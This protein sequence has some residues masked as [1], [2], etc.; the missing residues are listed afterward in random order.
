MNFCPACRWNAPC[1]GTR[2]REI[3]ESNS[4]AI[5]LFLELCPYIINL[6]D[7]QISLIKFANQCECKN[8]VQFKLHKRTGPHFVYMFE[9]ECC[10]SVT[11][12]VRFASA[13]RTAATVQIEAIMSEP[14]YFLLLIALHCT[15][16]HF[17]ALQSNALV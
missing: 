2:K 17:T 6:R 10:C 13:R 16:L 5:G 12:C 15:A 9:S 3:N 4:Y 14:G 7:T 11:H 1:Q 8:A